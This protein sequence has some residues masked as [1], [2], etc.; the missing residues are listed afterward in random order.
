VWLTANKRQVCRHSCV[1]IDTHT[2][3]SP[4]CVWVCVGVC[5]YATVNPF[6]VTWILMKNSH[7]PQ[8]YKKNRRQK[9]RYEPNTQTHPLFSQCT[10]FTTATLCITFLSHRWADCPGLE[11]VGMIWWGV[12]KPGSV[13]DIDRLS[14]GGTIH[15]GPR[16]TPHHQGTAR[17]CSHQLPLIPNSPKLQKCS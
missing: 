6:D 11:A 12:V 8:A 10:T 3:T 16:Q 13:L 5:M 4:V 2:P 9:E 14:L 7:M 17:K 15:A 1:T